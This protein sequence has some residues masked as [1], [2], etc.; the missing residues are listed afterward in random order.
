MKVALSAHARAVVI[1]AVVL[2]DAGT[3]PRQ[4]DWKLKKG[5]SLTQATGN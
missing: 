1:V 3:L 5:V 2:V 4:M